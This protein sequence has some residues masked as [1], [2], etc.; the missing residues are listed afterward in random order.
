MTDQTVTTIAIIIAF[1]ATG[2]MVVIVERRP[3]G[4]SSLGALAA[5]VLAMTISSVMATFLSI[6]F[7]FMPIIRDSALLWTNLP[8]RIRAVLSVTTSLMLTVT[9]LDTNWKRRG[10]RLPLQDNGAVIVILLFAALCF[11]VTGYSMG[12]L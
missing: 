12:W 10:G 2:A 8:P 7:V 1:I 3:P 11:T 4:E 6:V 5:Y 9:L